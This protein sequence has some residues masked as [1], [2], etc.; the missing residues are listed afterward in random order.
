MALPK[1]YK[2]E[3]DERHVFVPEPGKRARFMR[4]DLA[5]LHDECPDCESPVGT[6]CTGPRG[7]ISSGHLSRRRDIYGPC[8]DCGERILRPTSWK[9]YCRN[10]SGV[11]RRASTT[12]SAKRYHAKFPER[13]KANGAVKDAIRRGI[14]VRPD[15]CE[16][17]N[18][19]AGHPYPIH[20]HHHSYAPE[21]HLDVE[22]LCQGCHMRTHANERQETS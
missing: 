9:L 2:I 11:R 18:R 21:H 22:W 10:C 8:V 6:P 1:H 4:V 12:Q 3:G 16:Q 17:C 19:L 13:I 20:A 5:V 7:W 15:R 14:L